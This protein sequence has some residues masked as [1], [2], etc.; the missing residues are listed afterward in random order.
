MGLDSTMSQDRNLHLYFQ[1]PTGVL[2]NLFRSW[3]STNT[4]SSPKDWESPFD[5]DIFT[6]MNGSALRPYARQCYQCMKSE[7]IFFQ[8]ESGGI[9]AGALPGKN[10]DGWEG[11]YFDG[12]PTASNNTSIGLASVAAVN[13]TRSIATYYRSESGVLMQLTYKVDKVYD[14]TI[15]PRTIGEDTAI[16]AFAVGFNES[17]SSN[18]PNPLSIQVL[19]ADPDSTDGV[20]LTYLEN[21][22]WKAKGQVTDLADCTSRASMA[23]THD[24]QVFCV[25]DGEEGVEIKQWAWRGNPAG[26]SSTFSSYESVGNVNTTIT[27]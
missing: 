6:G 26:S 16:T 3:I 7:Y 12:S 14:Y 11:R 9:N 22:G 19:T 4:V 1:S 15:L 23:S 8:S 17:D 10:S 13:G 5:Y 25:V 24:H 18:N 20:L 2:K 27:N 21:G